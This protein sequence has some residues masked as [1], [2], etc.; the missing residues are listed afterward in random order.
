MSIERSTIEW[1]IPPTLSSADLRERLGLLKKHTD[2]PPVYEEGRSAEDFLRRKSRSHSNRLQSSDED[3]DED[4]DNEAFG[5]NVLKVPNPK[6]DEKKK[7]GR[8]RRG[9]SNDGEEDE[10]VARLK[11]EDAEKRLEARKKKEEEKR[12]SIKSEVYIRDSD[13]EENE[14]RDKIFFAKEK[15]LRWKMGTIEMIAEAADNPK[16]RKKRKD[17]EG[18]RR[19]KVRR[20]SNR[21]DTDADSNIGQEESLFVSTGSGEHDSDESMQDI[22][23]DDDDP[24]NVDISSSRGTS[25]P[26]HPTGSSPDL[27]A[28]AEPV[29]PRAKE[30]ESGYITEGGDAKHHDTNKLLEDEEGLE[31]PPRS[32]IKNL[33]D[34]PPKPS[35]TTNRRRRR[36]AIMV[37][38]EE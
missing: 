25:L 34:N 5:P 1:E 15:E 11:A 29:P 35:S 12:K 28:P 20:V 23:S 24:T 2:E 13:D 19:K 27:E 21:N 36:Q 4:S 9:N 17:Y 33:D 16:K 18:S 37:S 10:E 7:L 6:K 30:I 22:S 32:D 31:Q 14:E 26:R 38:D 3:G 8:R